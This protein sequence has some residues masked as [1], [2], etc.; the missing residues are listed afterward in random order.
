MNSFDQIVDKLQEEIFEDTKKAYGELGFQRWRKPL[1]RGKMQNPD[2]HAKIKGQCGDTMEI[3]LKFEKD[4]VINASFLTDGCG[5]ST[6]CGSFAAEMALQKNPDQLTGITGEAILNKLGRFPKEE[7]HC[8]YLAAETL[9][10]ALQIYMA[11]QTLH[12][13]GGNYADTELTNAE[14]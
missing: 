5:S 1:Y 7:T 10:K 2:V 3:F 11:G 13:H 6:V 8:A 4:R 12:Q 14:K 9:Q